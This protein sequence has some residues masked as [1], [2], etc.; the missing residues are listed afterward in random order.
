MDM[1]WFLLPEP[2]KKVEF[3]H[4]PLPVTGFKETA[5]LAASK[6]LWKAGNDVFMTKDGDLFK[7]L[8]AADYIPIG[9]ELRVDGIMSRIEKVDFAA[10]R[11]QLTNIEHPDKP[12]LYSETLDYIRS[13]VE[14]AGLRIYETLDKQEKKPSSIRDKLKV[15][16]KEAAAKP[17]HT[18]KKT[19]EREM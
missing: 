11:V 15:A 6:R 1:V 5:W 2:C 17:H 18:V 7:D 4:S 13:Y 14:D 16:Q 8:K 10:D 12:I 19:Q 9:A 3:R